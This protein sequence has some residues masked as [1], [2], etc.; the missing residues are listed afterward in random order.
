MAKRWSLSISILVLTFLTASA[1]ADEAT[2][3][4]V[5]QSHFSGHQVDS[6]KKIPNLGLYEVVV[7]EEVFYTDEKANYFFFGH[8]VDTKTRSSMTNE[9]IQEIKAAIAEG[10]FKINPEAIADRLI[11]SARD[12]LNNNGKRQA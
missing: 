7:G 12:L 11:E 1:W 10:R 4:K 8:I 6:L 9:R 3:K 2:I 5:V